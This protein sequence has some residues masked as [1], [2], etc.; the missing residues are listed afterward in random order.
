MWIT[1]AGQTSCDHQVSWPESVEIC[2]PE[3]RSPG[4]GKTTTL[5]MFLSIVKWTA[6]R[7][8]SIM[9]QSSEQLHVFVHYM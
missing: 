3:N 2:Q 8:T 5:A 4:K 7:D 1:G 9:H 6:C